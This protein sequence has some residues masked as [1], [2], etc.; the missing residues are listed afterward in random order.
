MKRVNKRKEMESEKI[1]K[2]RGDQHEGGDVIEE[3]VKQNK[4]G[5]HQEGKKQETRNQGERNYVQEVSEKEEQW[6]T[7][8]R[9]QSKNLEQV[10]PKTAWRACSPQH[11]KVIDDSQ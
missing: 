10:Q 9:K 11:K 4:K 1:D 3:N 2:S 6:Q 5:N 7:Q 8:R